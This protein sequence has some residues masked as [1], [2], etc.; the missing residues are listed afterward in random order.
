MSSS[1]L[2]DDLA[3][4][5]IER[6]GS[7]KQ[8]ELL[9]EIPQ[10]EKQPPR[11]RRGGGIG[12]TIMMVLLWMIPL[13]A[14]AGGGIYA[15]K[16]YD[17]LRSKTK[18]T[19]GVVQTLTTGEAEK[20]LSAKGFLKARRESK[21]TAKAAGRVER[22]LVEE[23]SRVKQGDVL[24]TLEHRDLDAQLASKKAS[25]DRSKADLEEARVDLA[26]KT[27]KAERAMR[28]YRQRSLSAE[29]FESA[30]A[31]R[32]M[33]AAKVD[34]LAASI[35]LI[36]ANIEEA[37]SALRDMT[38]L[39]PFN[40]TVVE[41][42][43]E[44]GEVVTPSSKTIV[45]IATLDQMDVETDIAENLLSRVAVGQPAEI[46]VSAIPNRRYRGR[47]RQIIP[48][49]D[50]GR[51][52]VKVKVE[53]DDPDEHLFPEL[54]ATVYF[55]PDKKRSERDLGTYAYVQKSAI[56]EENGHSYVWVVAGKTS[57]LTR[58]A[59]E[60]AVTKDDLARVES[61]LKTGETVVLEPSK[62]LKEGEVVQVE[63]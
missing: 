28:L 30:D 25:L 44:S 50:R 51:G 24:A 54:A 20:V 53:I 58:R 27:R 46:S 21:I 60:A 62:T 4:L 19:V 56:F 47:L 37:E 55:L 63:Q 29:E 15:Y 33:S 16:Q 1:T 61:G 14:I 6:K 12:L 40:A 39:A 36:E 31:V 8:A 52:T 45:A 49:G 23:G 18:V 59:I 10:F 41:K 5:R 26:E 48:M 57:S 43:T 34:G 42:A 17:M 13:G 38:I 7:R 3:S 11:S 9:D 32:K 2:R 22:V 35:K